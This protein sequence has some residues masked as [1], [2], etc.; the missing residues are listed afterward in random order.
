MHVQGNEWYGLKLSGALKWSY[1]KKVFSMYLNEGPFLTPVLNTPEI[2]IYICSWKP[3][4][5]FNCR[6]VTQ[7]AWF[8]LTLEANCIFSRGKTTSFLVV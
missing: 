7:V 6:V 5:C 2:Y 4:S 1:S 3:I 8:T